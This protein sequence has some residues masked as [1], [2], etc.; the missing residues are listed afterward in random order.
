MTLHIF[1]RDVSGPLE[2]AHL[3]ATFTDGRQRLVR[4]LECESEKLEHETSKQFGYHQ[5]RP[6]D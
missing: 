5:R 6:V 4:R 1:G 2:L 3:V